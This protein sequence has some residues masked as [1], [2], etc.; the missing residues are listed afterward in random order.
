M[1]DTLRPD[2]TKV[3]VV[4]TGLAEGLGGSDH[5]SAHGAPLTRAFVFHPKPGKLRG[6]VRS[7]RNALW[8]VIIGSHDATVCH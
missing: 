3:D 6:L 4:T 7:W 5:A 2:D 1:S 8:L